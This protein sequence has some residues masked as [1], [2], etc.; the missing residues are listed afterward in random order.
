MVKSHLMITNVVCAR[1]FVNH[2]G[3]KKTD[4]L[5]NPELFSKL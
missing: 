2:D 1:G 3:E 5:G 4:V